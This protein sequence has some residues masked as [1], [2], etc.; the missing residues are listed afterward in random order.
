MSYKSFVRQWEKRNKHE[1]LASLA[2]DSALSLFDVDIDIEKRKKKKKREKK[3][4]EKEKKREGTVKKSEI[5]INKVEE[6]ELQ[7]RSSC[8]QNEDDDEKGLFALL[9]ISLSYY[10]TIILLLLLLLPYLPH[11]L[12]DRV[13]REFPPPRRS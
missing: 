7:Q 8:L 3:K 1:F 5:N 6:R 10:Y 9:G 12:K 4:K 11:Y 13:I 2:R